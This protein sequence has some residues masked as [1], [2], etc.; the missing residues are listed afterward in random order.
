M[1]KN[2]TSDR[3]DDHFPLNIRFKL[4]RWNLFICEFEDEIISE[5]NML[6]AADSHHVISAQQRKLNLWAQSSSAARTFRTAARKKTQLSPRW[7]LSMFPDFRLIPRENNLAGWNICVSS[8][9]RWPRHVE[10]TFGSR[11]EYLARS[12]AAKFVG[13]F[14]TKEDSFQIFSWNHPQ[15]PLSDSSS[16]QTGVALITKH[17]LLSVLSELQSEAE[18]NRYSQ[19]QLICCVSSNVQKCRAAFRP[20][21]FSFVQNPKI[22]S[23]LWYTSEQIHI[24]QAH[25]SSINN[26]NQ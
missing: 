22:F 1:N 13:V 11:S 3:R 20:Q 8:S 2:Q 7:L 10:E 23:L 14:L 26:S 16:S 5:T 25:I 6:S 9:E 4:R 18:T 24:S 21:I 15:D 19:C 17:V 12:A